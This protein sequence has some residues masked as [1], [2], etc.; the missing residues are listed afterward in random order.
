MTATPPLSAEQHAA[1]RALIG[2]V[3]A[4]TSS[5]IAELAQ[6]IADRRSHDHP[7][8]HEDWFCANLSGWAGDRMAV[9]LRR[10][11]DAEA[12]LDRARSN[13]TYWRDRYREESRTCWDNSL[14]PGGECCAVCGQPVESEPC[15]EHHPATVADRLRA[16]LAAARS[17]LSSI[18]A[19]AERAERKGYDLDTADILQQARAARAAAP[20]ATT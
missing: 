20:T 3:P 1:I 10:L 11:I 7:T 8:G 12:E 13:A 19:D 18:E 6:S 17:A 2:D 9:V 4:A 14:P 5:L 15:P 16:E